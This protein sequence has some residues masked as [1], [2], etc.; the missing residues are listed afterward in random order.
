MVTVTVHSDSGTYSL[1]CASLLMAQVT[2]SRLVH[3][4]AGMVV[5][6]R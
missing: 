5:V 3:E 2:A 1:V 6:S 4:N